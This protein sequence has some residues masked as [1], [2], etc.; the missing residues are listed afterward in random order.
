MSEISNYIKKELEKGFSLKNIKKKLSEAGHDILEIEK[1]A[2][3]FEKKEEKKITN[4]LKKHTLIATV[5]I[6]LIIL[7]VIFIKTK[8]TALDY[9]K[10]LS[11]DQINEE[12]K[13]TGQQQKLIS[14]SK[15][16]E[17]NLVE[18]MDEKNLC[19]ALA[20]RETDDT[21]LCDHIEEIGTDFKQ[22][23]CINKLYWDSEC[24]YISY[25][26]GDEKK[27][28]LDKAIRERDIAQCASKECL[29]IITNLALDEKDYSICS[30]N[31]KCI[32]AY[33]KKYNEEEACQIL[34][35]PGECITLILENSMEISK[36]LLVNL[37][38]KIDS[39]E[40]G[41]IEAFLKSILVLVN[42]PPAGTPKEGLGDLV[43][44]VFK[45]TKDTPNFDCASIQEIVERGDVEG[46]LTPTTRPI[47]FLVLADY[48]NNDCSSLTGNDKTFCEAL[49]AS[50]TSICES[51]TSYKEECSVLVDLRARN[52]PFYS[53]HKSD[54]GFQ[55]K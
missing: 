7:V 47:H 54:P 1:E 21:L 9:A 44:D 8:P 24:D 19:F 39:G 5:A 52:N 26:D 25:M 16:D 37:D 15:I 33:V 51:L 18:G 40:E 41:C 29:D 49:V 11:L 48:T 27:C 6:L 22:Y 50:D 42:F 32:L 31:K 28:R 38:E 36:C 3:A 13:I 4:F 45:T 17:C 34:D 55:M 43:C 23:G 12:E 53:E 2:V 35:E 30:E 10:N 20:A 46:T 14:Q